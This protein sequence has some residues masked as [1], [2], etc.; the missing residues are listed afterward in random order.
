MGRFATVSSLT[1]DEHVSIPIDV[2][3]WKSRPTDWSFETRDSGTNAE[4]VEERKRGTTVTVERLYPSVAARFGDPAFISELERRIASTYALFIS[5]GLSITLNGSKIS[6]GLPVLASGT[7]TPARRRFE[8]DGVD[9]LILASV[10]PLQDTS[11]HGW[12]VFCNGRM[13]VEAD[14][15]PLTGWGDRLPTF[16]VG[17]YR[18]FVGFAYF[19]S[20]DVRKLP[21][22]TT[23]QGVDADS[24][25]Y[26]AALLEMSIQGRAVT[27]FL[28]SLYPRD[29]DADPT[30]EREV[31]ARASAVSIDK[32]ELTDRA[33]TVQVPRVRPKESVSIQYSR[34][35]G[36][37]DR[38]GKHLGR[39]GMSASK[40][41]EYTFD[42]FVDQELD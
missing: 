17:K 27:S 18:R 38:I 23:K 21:W 9:V 7:M 16:H 34:P 33:F 14:Q 32:I 20:D 41:G 22:R 42:Y 31:L 40:V 6:S 26:Q 8:Y 24:E 29:V 30:L 37:V 5:A 15:T 1:R 35:K 19:R 11:P 4:P 28:D 13:V 12:Y 25:L 36:L 3:D 10:A 39:R 2:D